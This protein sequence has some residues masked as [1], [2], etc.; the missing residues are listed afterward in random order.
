ML[1]FCL[2]LVE[3]VLIY[4][5]WVIF[6]LIYVHFGKCAVRI[7]DHPHGQPVEAQ[8]NELKTKY[9]QDRNG[10]NGGEPQL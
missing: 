3:N 4:I 6:T 5:F 7:K 8:I 1:L 2:L 10:S 9:F